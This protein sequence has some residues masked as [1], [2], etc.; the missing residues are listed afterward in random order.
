MKR[1]SLISCG[2]TTQLSSNQ[3]PG[4][5]LLAFLGFLVTPHAQEVTNLYPLAPATKLEAFDTNVGTIVIKASTELG[6]VAAKTGAISVKYKEFT[7]TA[8]GRK[9]HGIAIEITRPG[10][11]KDVM[12]IDYDELASLLNAIDYFGKLDVSVSSLDAFDAAY[13]TK[14]GFR[15]AALGAR[16]SGLV[17]F[18]VRD[19]RSNA[20]PVVLTRD[21]MVRLSTLI[22]QAKTQ[23]DGLPR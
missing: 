15:I 14:G 1:T 5:F 18:G 10:Q 7:E 4:F 13:T 16:R 17:Q 3:I 19:T 21:E 23:L 8:T 12:L 6:A 9:E 22:D 20:P 11:F 2:N